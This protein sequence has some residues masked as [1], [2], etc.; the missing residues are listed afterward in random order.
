MLSQLRALETGKHLKGLPDSDEEPVAMCQSGHV[1]K[2]PVWVC[3]AA[4]SNEAVEFSTAKY[5][6]VGERLGQTAFVNDSVFNGRKACV[7][8]HHVGA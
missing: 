3:Q 5:E 6:K 7:E 8:Q 2:W 1:S 4:D